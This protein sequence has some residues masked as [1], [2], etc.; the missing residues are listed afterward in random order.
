[1]A[2]HLN[3][4]NM[5]GVRFMYRRFRPTAS[6]YKDQECHGVDIQVVDRNVFDP[7]LMGLELLAVTMRL[8]PGKFD[9]TMHLLGSDDVLAALKGGKSG[10]QILEESRAPLERFRGIRARY[11]LYP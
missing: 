4:L 1:V 7:V 9:P 10:R 6:V 11:L 2:A 8:H 3:G 5:P